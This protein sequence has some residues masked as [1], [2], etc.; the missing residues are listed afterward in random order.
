MAAS[1][2]F[3]TAC[4]FGKRLQIIAENVPEFQ[5]ILKRSLKHFGDLGFKLLFKLFDVT[6]SLKKKVY[7]GCNELF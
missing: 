5:L 2:C 1:R 3:Q 6:C 4:I 7:M